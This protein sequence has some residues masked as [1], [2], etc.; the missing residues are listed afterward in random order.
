MYPLFE[1]LKF[2][3]STVKRALTSNDG[4]VLL[5]NFSWLT[6]LQ[7]ASYIFPFITYPY[8]ARV[9][10]VDG[11]GKIA[12]AAAIVAWIQTIVDWG[13]GYT[14]TREVA[15]NRDDVAKLS[16]IF[17]NVLWARL[18]LALICFVLL[19]VLTFFIPL[20][21][22]NAVVIFYSFLLIPGHIFFPEWFFQG[23]E[24][25]KYTSIFNLA[26]KFF[27]TIAIFIFIIKPE[28]YVLQPLLTS[29]G[30]LLS[31][32]IS[33]FVVYYK[34][35]VKV[36]SPDIKVIFGYLKDSYDVFLGNLFPSMYNNFTAVF[37]GSIGNASATGL[38]DGG[39]KFV[40]VIQ[41][42]IVILGRTFFP[43]LNRRN[44]KHTMYAHLNLGIALVASISLFL[45]AP[46]FV[47]TFLSIEFEDSITVL[48]I[49]SPSIFFLALGT[50]YCV[51]YLYVIGEDKIA[52]TITIITSLIGLALAYPM[53]K[54][55]SFIGAAINV[56][57]TRAIMG[58][59]HM[60]AAKKIMNN[61]NKNSQNE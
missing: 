1:H 10:G 22:Q 26:I 21:K 18:F 61:R 24:K 38:Y 45:L 41:Q 52:T 14:G 33:F 44:D 48:R 5:S 60:M 2:S 46:F 20:L 51:N 13:F 9:I 59:W 49:L 11:F 50:V 29:A 36:K 12:F 31:G 30:F 40:N 43:F 19:V 32:L 55:F 15:K 3:F 17:S 34:W 35:G 6:A 56:L 16:S 23:I 7:I 53:I 47:H 27:F 54:W 39:N 58:V 28:D 57:F 37:L 42:F 4:K 8:L 25:M